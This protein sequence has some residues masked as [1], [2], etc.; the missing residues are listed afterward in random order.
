[1]KKILLITLSI[2]LSLTITS[3]GSQKN[4]DSETASDQEA[5]DYLNKEDNEAVVADSSSD[6]GTSFEFSSDFSD[7]K[8]ALTNFIGLYTSY[9]ESINKIIEESPEAEEKAFELLSYYMIDLEIAF[10]P[11]YDTFD[12]TGS[13]NKSSGNLMFTSYTGTKE[14]DGNLVRFYYDHE[15]TEDEGAYSTGDIV[16]QD[17]FFDTKKNIL[18]LEGTDKSNNKLVKRNVYEMSFV[19]DTFILQYH[20]FDERTMSKN[21]NS[22]FLKITKDSLEYFETTK[23]P[24]LDFTY[25]NIQPGKDIPLDSLFDGGNVDFKMLVKDGKVS[26][27]K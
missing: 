13:A 10:I 7:Y 18:W 26:F 17:G 19:D 14:K 6:Q 11:I 24:T 27:D 16:K 5:L 15:Y 1:M 8:N 25:K 20:N 12:Y 4:K 9:K 3:C 22:A 23:E 2:I 21:V